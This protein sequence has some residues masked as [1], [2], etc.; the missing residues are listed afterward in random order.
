MKKLTKPKLL[1]KSLKEKYIHD[2]K[3]NQFSSSNFINQNKRLDLSPKNI[4]DLH[5]DILFILNHPY[6]ESIRAWAFNQLRVITQWCKKN[7]KRYEEKLENSGL[8]YSTCYS[9]FSFTLTQ[10]MKNQNFSI[11]LNSYKEESEEFNEIFSISLP[12]YLRDK[13]QLGMTNQEWFDYLCIKEKNQLSFILS[14]FGQIKNSKSLRDLMFEK[15]QFG[16]Q[17]YI[18]TDR[19]S[20]V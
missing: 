5:D 7:K 12:S 8:P 2:I 3:S 13:S 11:Q 1:K 20:V 19:K 18:D 9:L 15:Q 17:L 14:Q 10:W 6:S 4:K 16:I